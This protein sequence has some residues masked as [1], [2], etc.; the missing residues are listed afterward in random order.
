MKAACRFVIEFPD[1]RSLEA[2]RIAI[3]HEG[4]LSGRAKTSVEG[5]GRRLEIVIEAA[6]VVALRASANAFLR[7]IQVIEGIEAG[8]EQ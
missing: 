3:S 6:D 7:A 1:D 2:A 4:G 8:D 5:K